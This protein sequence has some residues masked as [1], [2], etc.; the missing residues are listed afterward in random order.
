MLIRDRG[1]GVGDQQEKGD[2][3][4]KARIPMNE[5]RVEVAVKLDVGR[6]CQE[7]SA[8]QIK[9]LIEGIAK[10]IAAGERR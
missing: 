9:A 2:V 6:L 3:R 10:V 8:E 7:M 1:L 5:I 4:I